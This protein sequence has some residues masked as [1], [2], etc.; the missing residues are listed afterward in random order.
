MTSDTDIYRSAKLLVDEH[1]ADAPIHAV[2]RVDELIE[3]GDVQGVA[4]WKR[5]LKA[6]E[7]LLMIGGGTIH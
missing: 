3:A 7:E 4:T 1:G 6:V 2:M 5:I